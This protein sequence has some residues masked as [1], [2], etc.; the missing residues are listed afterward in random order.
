NADRVI[1]VD[2]RR[3]QARAKSAA[4]ITRHQPMR[5]PTVRGL[6]KRRILVNYRVDPAVLTPLLP[7]PF[8]PKIVRGFG[9]AG[10]CLIR[11]KGLRPAGL[12][13]WLGISSENAAHRVAVEWDDDG[14]T[15]EGDCPNPP[16]R[17]G[18]SP[19]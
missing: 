14:T 12:P 6:S 15:R 18:L 10:I 4:T 11:L 2:A 9:M 13:A 17:M 5:I 16:R 8:R 1:T 7:M 19:S 3:F